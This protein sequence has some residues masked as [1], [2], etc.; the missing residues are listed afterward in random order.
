MAMMESTKRTIKRTLVAIA[1]AVSFFGTKPL[2]DRVKADQ[3]DA[4]VS[5][6]VT[7]VSKKYTCSMQ[8]ETYAASPLSQSEPLRLNHS[9]YTL[10]LAVG[11]GAGSPPQSVS[12]S[13]NHPYSNNEFNNKTLKPNPNVPGANQYEGQTQNLGHAPDYTAFFS[14]PNTE[15]VALVNKTWLSNSEL[16]DLGDTG[17]TLDTGTCRP[18]SNIVK[19]VF[20]RPCPG[21][22]YDPT[23]FP[24]QNQFGMFSFPACKGPVFDPSLSPR[25]FPIDLTKLQTLVGGGTL[26]AACQDLMNAGVTDIFLPFKVDDQLH[27]PQCGAY[28]QLLYPSSAYSGRVSPIITS[29]QKARFDPNGSIMSVCK[30]VYGNKTIRF[31][32]WFPVFQD[33]YA[34][35]I[36]GVTGKLKF[37]LNNI[38]LS[39]PGA[40][41]LDG[42]LDSKGI[43]LW[44]ASYTSHL[45]ADPKSSDVRN[46]ELAILTEITSAYPGLYGI[47]LD[48][49]R[50]PQPEDVFEVSTPGGPIQLIHDSSTP[51]NIA[52]LSIWNYDSSA[53]ETFVKMVKT[54]FPNKTLSADVFASVGVMSGVG[55]DKVSAQVDIIMPMAYSYA[56]KGGTSEDMGNYIATLKTAYPTKKMVACVRGWVAPQMNGLINDL[57][58]DI[59]AVRKGGADGYAP[60]TYDSLL[61][62]TGRSTLTSIKGKL[63]Y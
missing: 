4:A 49:I 60:F 8:A 63:G 3:P 12:L 36:Q 39:I 59:A 41:K 15:I 31:H 40:D 46:Q 27:A 19:G 18:V 37:S 24:M 47:N 17:Y 52:K 51:P 32:A 53:V 29:A 6:S 61:S 26:K 56:G 42:F 23:M 9:E 7:A 43:P 50:Y 33:P 54:A 48:Y 38:P 2:V 57:T 44:D 21:S 10:E 55:Q 1:V 34:A 58:S 20:I 28:G 30:Q 14:A 25:R 45:F 62:Q 11:F 22:F 5:G 16:P 35:Q 13:S